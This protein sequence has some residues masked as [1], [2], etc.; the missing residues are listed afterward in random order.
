MS[1]TTCK[2]CNTSW[3]DCEILDGGECAS[4]L[5]AEVERLRA[6]RQ[7]VLKR[8]DLWL[9][10]GTHRNCDCPACEDLRQ[11]AIEAATV[12]EDK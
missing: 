2:S 11:V 9:V 3:D 1:N 7:R 5:R 12:G 10:L 6:E 4:C 8:I